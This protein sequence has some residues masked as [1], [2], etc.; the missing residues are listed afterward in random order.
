MPFTVALLKK[1]SKRFFGPPGSLFRKQVEVNDEI[2]YMSQ[3]KLLDYEFNIFGIYV[4]IS[5]IFAALVFWDIFLLEESYSCDDGLDCFVTNTTNNKILEVFRSEPVTDCKLH[6]NADENTIKCFIFVYR[7][8]PGIA[9]F[10]GLI[11][12]SKIIMNIIAAVFLTI[13][14]FVERKVCGWKVKLAPLRVIILISIAVFTIGAYTIVAILW[15]IIP[16]FSLAK[17]WEVFTFFWLWFLDV[18]SVGGG[19]HQSLM[20]KLNNDLH[21]SNIM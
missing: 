3:G 18:R 9:A 4:I 8:G 6:K 15:A 19:I 13:Y 2:L 14:G 12:M 21:Y 5:L 1:L 10:G 7:F 20:K 17:V 11:T 16:S